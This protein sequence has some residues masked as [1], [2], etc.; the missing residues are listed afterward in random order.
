MHGR[1]TRSLKTFHL[2]VPHKRTSD[3]DFMTFKLPHF[4]QHNAQIHEAR[5]KREIE[6][7]IIHYGI[8][9]DGGLHHLELEPNREFMHPNLIFEKRDPT[10]PIKNRDVRGIETKKLCHYRGTVRGIPKSKVALSVCDGLAGFIIINNKKYYIEPVD[11]HGP[12]QKGQHLHVIYHNHPDDS[13]MRCGTESPWSNNLFA[14]NDRVSGNFEKRDLGS[15]DRYL[16]VCVVCDKKFLKY[17]KNREVELYV[18][19]IMNMVSEFY[20]DS[21]IGNSMEVTVV[22]IVY[23]EREEKEIDLEINRNSHTTLDSFAKWVTKINAPK[24]SPNH[25]DMGALLTRHDLCA[26]GSN[27]CGLTGLA[28]TGMACDTEGSAGCINEDR[29]LPLAV[30]VAHELGHLLGAAHDEDERPCPVKD[31]DGSY[32]IMSPYVYLNTIRWSSCARKDISELLDQ[33]KGDCLNDE[34]TST[35]YPYAH[36]LPGVV[37]GE[38]EQCKFVFP[39]SVGACHP[40]KLEFCSNFL[41]K[42]RDKN[43][44][45]ANEGPADGT[46]CG[47]NKWCFRQKCI[48]MGGRP[49]AV[50]GG[51][52][53]WQS[54][55]ECSRTCGGG[56]A[57]QERFCDNPEPANRGRFCVGDRKRRKICNSEPCPEHTPSFRQ[58]QCT[59][60][61]K[62]PYNGMHL[63]WTAVW[64]FS[65]VCSLV[66]S[67]PEAGRVIQESVAKDGTL[68]NPG[69][70][71]IC[72][73]GVCTSVGCDYKLNS[74]AVEDRCGIC[75]GDGT[76]CKY[77]EGTFENEI[78]EANSAKTITTIPAGARKIR[79]EEKI[80]SQN[81][82][83][84]A[85]VNQEHYYL[86]KGGK[87]STEGEHKIAGSKAFY[88]R[89]G[90]DQDQLIINGP[91][92]ED[93]VILYLFY[94]S[95]NLG[96][97]YSWVEGEVDSSYEPKYNWEIGEY[98]PCNVRC[99][100]GTQE[101]VWS[102]VEEKA[103]K[104][105]PNFCTG[106]E[107]PGRN[108]IKNCNEQ[109]C[110]TRWKVGKWGKCRACKNK[111]GVR[112]RPVEC[113]RESP[114]MNA[115]DIIIEDS[116]C[117]GKKPSSVELCQADHRCS[118]KRRVSHIPGRFQDSVWSQMTLD[119]VP[120]RETNHSST[121]SSNSTTPNLKLGKFVV[122]K[123]PL[124]KQVLYIYDR[125]GQKPNM[126]DDAL[127]NFGDI[128]ED[129]FGKTTLKISG[130]FVGQLQHQY[131][132]PNNTGQFNIKC[133]K[134]KPDKTKINKKVKN[135]E[136]KTGRRYLGNRRIE[137]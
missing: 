119:S 24:N 14:D 75:N 84:V 73:Q 18:M 67:N 125:E 16:E 54:W 82:I 102:C 8:T 44:M 6:D 36:K 116:D 17:H 4:Y 12:N 49:E 106:I 25:H 131:E 23:L 123:V 98:G 90:D 63:K 118:R 30:I 19:T 136:K 120:K 79:V 130:K 121:E 97:D 2:S 87:T 94:K 7:E 31:A 65:M 21:S 124:N 80:D 45:G 132:N 129:T 61:D 5:K 93:I 137:N 33:G 108:D 110:Q 115:D 1:Y 27:D 96:V 126:S 117:E 29:G 127:E 40:R 53:E 66:C 101:A 15:K 56:L 38:V 47:E 48:E 10:V 55:S 109:P 81:C 83:A 88:R 34:P 26:P 13:K 86:N 77:M 9:I 113:I 68:C 70:K 89:L 41:C 112:V 95:E 43:C 85:D 134:I 32:F 62:E 37:Y 133:H 22:R 128:E 78:G 122:D 72:I 74:D 20:H 107:K 92:K 46:K 111:S 58:T 69:S 35:M 39:S 104:V 60:K 57:T 99:G 103:G 59:E 91:I 52:G 42:M 71:D 28:S 135:K 76:Q 3:G 50:N 105:S 51:W 114:K 100:G 64:D 11:K